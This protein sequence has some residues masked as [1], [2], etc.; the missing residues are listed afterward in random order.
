[1]RSVDVEF[2]KAISKTYNVYGYPPIGIPS[3]S[4]SSLSHVT[5]S[6]APSL[7]NN[8]HLEHHLEHH[9][10]LH[11]SFEVCVCVLSTESADAAGSVPVRARL[12]AA[13]GGLLQELG[14]TR[15]NNTQQYTIMH[16]LQGL[17]PSARDARHTRHPLSTEER[18]HNRFIQGNNKELIH[19]TQTK[20][21]K[22]PS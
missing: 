11:S 3:P 19:Y 16:R 13:Q 18:Q 9:F 14:E 20:M 5:E 21:N 2:D 10:T 4:L 8:A 17:Q 15:N 12:L 7:T 1:M 22:T 6:P